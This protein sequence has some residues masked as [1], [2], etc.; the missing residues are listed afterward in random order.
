MKSAPLDTAPFSESAAEIAELLKRLGI[1][2]TY[3]GFWQSVCAVRLAVQNPGTL[4]LVSKLLYPEVATQFG[5]NWR[6]IE[7]NIRT[8]AQVAWENNPDLLSEL[9]GFPLTRR[10]KAAHFISTL[11]FPFIGTLPFDTN[12]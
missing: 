7:R 12:S 6:V 1:S 5:V 2:S 3:N 9:A 4:M 10:P 8:V 11:S